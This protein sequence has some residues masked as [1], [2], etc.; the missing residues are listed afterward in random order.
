MTDGTATTDSPTAGGTNNPEPA[1]EDSDAPL[2]SEA[3]VPASERGEVGQAIEKAAP[4]DEPSPP[5][6][7]DSISAGEGGKAA[8][9][10]IPTASGTKAEVIIGKI[11][12]THD[13]ATLLWTARCSD[14]DHGLLGH[15]DTEE[16]AIAAKDDHLA[17][18]H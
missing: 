5:A 15:F 16:A 18:Q 6:R 1:T 14:P 4:E 2:K 17:S 11:P 13:L 8:E 3:A 12:D 9:V 7:E 10:E